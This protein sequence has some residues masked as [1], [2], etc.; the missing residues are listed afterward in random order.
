VVWLSMDGRVEPEATRREE[1][2]TKNKKRRM[3]KIDAQKVQELALRVVWLRMGPTCLARKEHN[4]LKSP[5]VCVCSRAS[6]GIAR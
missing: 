2:R 1:N 4:A 5:L 3:R 6:Y